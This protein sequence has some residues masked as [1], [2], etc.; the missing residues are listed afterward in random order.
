MIY[1]F[2]YF[3]FKKTAP[4]YNQTAGR[5]LCK[6]FVPELKNHPAYHKIFKK[7]REIEKILW[8]FIE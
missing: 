2:S 7:F 4:E 8:F 5:S 3:N 6:K 1:L